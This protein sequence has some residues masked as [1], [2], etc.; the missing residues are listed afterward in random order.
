MRPLIPAFVV[1]L[2]YVVAFVYI[3][4]DSYSQV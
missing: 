4:A 3:G 2:S 1:S